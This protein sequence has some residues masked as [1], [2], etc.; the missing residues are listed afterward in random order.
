MK[1]FCA[2]S[3]CGFCTCFLFTSMMDA[4]NQY[5]VFIVHQQG[6]LPNALPSVWIVLFSLAQQE[7]ITLPFDGFHVPIHLT[8]LS[9]KNEE[10]VCVAHFVN[11]QKHQINEYMCK[12]KKKC[13]YNTAFGG[14]RHNK[15]LLLY[16]VHILFLENDSVHSLSK[17]NI[18]MIYFKTFIS[19]VSVDP[20]FPKYQL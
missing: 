17:S 5:D 20:Y 16:H 6:F 15:G 3:L 10:N 9:S 7:S 19:L 14:V 2:F 18:V 1:H 12:N 11:D 4:R 8:C 13:V